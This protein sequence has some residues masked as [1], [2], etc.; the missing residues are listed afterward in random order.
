MAEFLEMKDKQN[1]VEYA[2]VDKDAVITGN[3]PYPGDS[4]RKLIFFLDV[5]RGWN[6]LFYYYDE[7]DNMVVTTTIP[8]TE[9]VFWKV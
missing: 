1:S 6:R 7:D 3:M 5:K 8:D 9:W 4:E 2:Y